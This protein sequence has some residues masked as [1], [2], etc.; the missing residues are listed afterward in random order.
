MRKILSNKE[1]LGHF[2]DCI[3]FI[4]K[5]TFKITLEHFLENYILNAAS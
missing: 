5:S 2:L 1:R 3:N 4:E